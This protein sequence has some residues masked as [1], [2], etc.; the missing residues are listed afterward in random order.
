MCPK[1]V[2][3]AVLDAAARDVV[4]TGV[5][6]G[7]AGDVAM[8]IVWIADAMIG[9]KGRQAPGRARPRK[10]ST[11]RCE[12]DSDTCETEALILSRDNYFNK[13]AGD[14]Q[15]AGAADAAGTTKQPA[16]ANDDIDMAE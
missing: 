10:S 2:M 15:N 1:T 12:E 14:S 7:M 8:V 9:A 5:T 11:E 4:V 3:V 6:V 16:V 13:P